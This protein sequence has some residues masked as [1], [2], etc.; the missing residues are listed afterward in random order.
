[1]VTALL[2]ALALGLIFGTTTVV[3]THVGKAITTN[4]VS[5][6]GGTVPKYV[7][8]GTGSTGAAAT[9]TDLSTAATEART[10]G[11][12]S[13][14]TTSQTN[15]TLQVVGTVTIAG[16][17]KTI[18]E[19]GLFDAAG[20][21][22]PPSGGNLYELASF[23]GLALDL[24]KQK[25]AGHVSIAVRDPDVRKMI[26]LYAAGTGQKVPLSGSTPR[27]ASIVEQGGRAY[28][29]PTYQY[30]QAYAYS[31]SLPTA[32]GGS[33]MMW[34]GQSQIVLNVNGQSAADLLEGRI[35]STVTPGYV[36][37]RYSDALASS[38][39]RQANAAMLQQAGLIV[40]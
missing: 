3:F 25:Y 1:M 22:S 40:A 7:G 23:T 21:G 34:P 36:Q 4:L 19:A 11:T 12:V 27:A 14:V 26:E 37:D 20:S 13:R 29:A 18:T 31:S 35:A 28:Q 9:A 16:A 32:G 39:R 15:D 33:P 5:G 6:I 10:S 30:G 24:A 38:D 2:A 17:G 8:W